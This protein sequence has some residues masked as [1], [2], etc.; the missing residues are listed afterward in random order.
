MSSATESQQARVIA[1]LRVFIKKVLADPTIA[2]KSMEIARKL[3]DEQDADRKI[4]EQIS[5][6]TNVRIPEKL[7]EADRIFLEIINDVLDDEAAL[8]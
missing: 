7:S 6:Q 5:A 8:Y 4:A 2:V 1:E 3:K